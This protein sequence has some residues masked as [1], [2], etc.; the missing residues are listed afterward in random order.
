MATNFLDL[1]FRKPDPKFPGPPNAQIYVKK[2]AKDENFDWPIISAKC[3]TFAEIDYQIKRL[4]G[5]LKT[6]RQ[7]ARHK[8]GPK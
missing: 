1:D 8:F 5:E 2:Y 7:K 6:I 3:V 4:E